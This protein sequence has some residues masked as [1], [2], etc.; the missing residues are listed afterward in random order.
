[1]SSSRSPDPWGRGL[2]FR[3]S[4]G[5][6]GHTILKADPALDVEGI[7][8]REQMWNCRR[9]ARY[10]LAVGRD[11]ASRAPDLRGAA[12]RLETAGMV[13]GVTYVDGGRR[14]VGGGYARRLER[15]PRNTHLILGGTTRKRSDYDHRRRLCVGVPRQ[16]YLM[17]NRARLVQA[18]FA[19]V[20]EKKACAC[21]AMPR[22]RT[23]KKP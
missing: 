18:A 22:V 17:E 13:A 14:P 2:L 9:G 1:M 11:A 21:F 23:S 5:R 7:R 15:L 6:S 12:H 10:W 20:P 4:V 19:E 8:L 3:R 16:V